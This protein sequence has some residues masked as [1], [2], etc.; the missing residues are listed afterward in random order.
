MNSRIPRKIG[1]ETSVTSTLRP[2]GYLDLLVDLLIALGTACALLGIRE[3][4]HSNWTSVAEVLSFHR[5]E[6]KK[7]GNTR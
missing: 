1:P 5:A 2:M 3:P 6:G 7:S 4:R